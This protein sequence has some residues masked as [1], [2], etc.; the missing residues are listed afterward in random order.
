MTIRISDDALLVVVPEDD[1]LPVLE[2]DE[3]VL[4]DVVLLQWL[5]CTVIEDVAILVDSL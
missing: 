4:S 1:R 2:A 3:M 5:E